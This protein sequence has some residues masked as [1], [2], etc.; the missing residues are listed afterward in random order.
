MASP[1]RVGPSCIGCSRSKLRCQD[2][3]GQAPCE[4]CTAKGLDCERPPPGMSR[5]KRACAQCKSAKV[6]CDGNR[7][8]GG[9]SVCVSFGYICS[10]ATVNT[11]DEPQAGADANPDSPSTTEAP[12]DMHEH[13]G[14]LT[15]ADTFEGVQADV[16]PVTAAEPFVP[17]L[18]AAR[19]STIPILIPVAEPNSVLAPPSVALDL[20]AADDASSSTPASNPHSPSRHWLTCFAPSPEA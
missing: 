11:A 6:R 1:K 7:Q 15:V 5:C 3:V 9:C 14:P 17:V 19:L 4:R 16:G 8:G 18:S 2:V 20:S 12:E 13:A 10:F